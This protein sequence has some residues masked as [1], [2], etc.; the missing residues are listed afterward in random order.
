MKV[1]YTSDV[2]EFISSPA[3]DMKKLIYGFAWYS[4]IKI[5]NLWIYFFK[6]CVEELY[7]KLHTAFS[8]SANLILCK[9][10]AYMET[11]L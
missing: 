11:S 3:L 6:K 8:Y 7:L 2:L 5:S 4:N 1:I 10:N 9:K